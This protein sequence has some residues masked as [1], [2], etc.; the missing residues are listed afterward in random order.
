M[1]YMLIIK[2]DNKIT[3][4]KALKLY[5]SKVIKTRQ[6]SELSKRKEFKK[7]SVVKRDGLSKAKYVQK[8]FNS[9]DD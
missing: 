4:E 3:I 6:S 1:Y 9:N 2:I 5:K 7:P 8:K